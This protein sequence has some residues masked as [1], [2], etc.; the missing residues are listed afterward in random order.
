[1]NHRFTGYVLAK[2]MPL[3]TPACRF[4]VNFS[5]KERRKSNIIVFRSF[6]FKKNWNLEVFTEIF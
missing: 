6:F 4:T 2:S 1:M 5:K 3:K